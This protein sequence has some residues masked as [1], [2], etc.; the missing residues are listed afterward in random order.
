[1]SAWIPNEPREILP[2]AAEVYPKL[3]IKPAVVHTIKAERT[4]WDKATILHREFFRPENTNTPIRY[5]RHYYD[6]YKMSCSSIKN[7]ALADYKLLADVVTRKDKLYHCSWAKY[8]L[9]KPGT[10]RL[11]PNNNSRELIKKDYSAMQG[12]IF[13]DIP[14]WE[15]ILEHLN[16]LEN[17]INNLLNP[18]LHSR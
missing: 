9:A 4:F 5:S 16:K 18:S 17:E 1:M 7:S 14:A 12:M 11:M 10:L 8:E 3:E 2:Y 13:G 6:L 15:V